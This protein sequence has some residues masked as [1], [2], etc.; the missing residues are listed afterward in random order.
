MM[1]CWHAVAVGVDVDAAVVA[2]VAAVPRR[3]PATLPVSTVS[4][5]LVVLDLTVS[6]FVL[7]V[8][9]VPMTQSTVNSLTTNGVSFINSS[10][11]QST[12]ARWHTA[13]YS[14]T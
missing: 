13:H 5:V 3:D 4:A 10:G 6:G 14:F 8:V 12:N 7:L 1:Q 9:L 2:A 11:D